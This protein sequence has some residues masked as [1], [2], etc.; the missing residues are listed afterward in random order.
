MGPQP[1]AA[2]SGHKPI[3]NTGRKLRLLIGI[4]IY[5]TKAIIYF[6]GQILQR[7]SGIVVRQRTLLPYPV[8]KRYSSQVDVPTFIYLFAIEM[9]RWES[10]DV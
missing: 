6:L 1:F 8:S 2:S 9:P 10:D 3:D 4:G 7:Q 5:S